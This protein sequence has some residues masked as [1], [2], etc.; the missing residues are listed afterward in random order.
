MIEQSDE[1]TYRQTVHHLRCPECSSSNVAGDSTQPPFFGDRD[2]RYPSRLPGMSVL[3]FYG[4]G[5]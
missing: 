3:V 2:L 4:C 1:A 5:Y